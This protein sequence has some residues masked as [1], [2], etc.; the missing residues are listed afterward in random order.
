MNNKKIK[1][2]FP[3]TQWLHAACK[4]FLLP[5]DT[6]YQNVQIEINKESKKGCYPQ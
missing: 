4:T 2:T 5:A 1:V 3:L 6:E